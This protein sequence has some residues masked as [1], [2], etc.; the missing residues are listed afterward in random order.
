MF[1][2]FAGLDGCQL[3][4][5]VALRAEHG[6]PFV[7]AAVHR[8][9]V[10][11]RAEDVQTGSGTLFQTQACEGAAKLSDRM[12]SYDVHWSPATT[13]AEPTVPPAFEAE[14]RKPIATSPDLDHIQ[15]D[16]PRTISF[17]PGHCG[18]TSECFC[19]DRGTCPPRDL[20]QDVS[21][22]NRGTTKGEDENESI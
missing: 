2:L 8:R 7:G 14:S 5:A 20:H 19:L 10:P 16:E 15:P 1:L 13:H 18:R 12:W 4:Q 9:I 11:P 21:Q 17:R 22:A 6:N 3:R